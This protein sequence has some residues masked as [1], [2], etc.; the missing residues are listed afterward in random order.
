MLKV[1]NALNHTVFL[2]DFNG[3]NE[4][5]K[6]TITDGGYD[7]ITFYFFGDYKEME[8]AMWDYCEN[9][10]K[11]WIFTEEEVEE[12]R[13]E[14]RNDNPN[15]NWDDP[16]NQWNDEEYLQDY[17][18]VCLNDGFHWFAGYAFNNQYAIYKPTEKENGKEIEISIDSQ[19]GET[20]KFRFIYTKE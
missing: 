19:F 14:F 20:M 6:I 11:K 17:H 4:C 1:E 13:R 9:H 12:K 15:I 8:E 18:S 10:A 5:H 7:G 3:E 2:N 16:E